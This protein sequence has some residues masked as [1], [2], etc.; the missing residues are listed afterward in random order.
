MAKTSVCVC[1]CAGAHVLSFAFLSLPLE[2][3]LWTYKLQFCILLTILVHSFDVVL[4][5]SSPTKIL[6]IFKV[7]LQLFLCF[8]FVRRNLSKVKMCLY[9]DQLELSVLL[10]LPPVVLRIVDCHCS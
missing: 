10:C 2:C 5:P 6:T 7:V 4:H 3:S 9:S 1:V 8:F